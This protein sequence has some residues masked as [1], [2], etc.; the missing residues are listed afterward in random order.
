[1]R[2]VFH[3]GGYP[4]TDEGIGGIGLRILEFATTLAPDHQVLVITRWPTDLFPDSVDVHVT[5]GGNG[6]FSPDDVVFFFDLPDLAALQAAAKAGAVVV[7]ENAAPIEHLEYP[8]YAARPDGDD[9]L[10]TV[11]ATYRYQLRWSDH[12]VCRSDVERLTLV[13]NLAAVGRLRP[14]DIAA[15][16]TLDHLISLVPI[17]YTGR[18]QPAA[19]PPPGTEPRFAWSGGLWEFY[20]LELVADAVAVCCARGTPVTV[21]FLHGAPHPDN[22][23]VVNR[24]AARAT[25]LGLSDRVRVWSDPLPHT[26]RG[27]VLAAYHGLICLGRRGV[28][29][30]TCVRLRLRDSL[31]HRLPLIV[32]GHGAT[33]ALVGEHGLGMVTASDADAVADALLA[34]ATQPRLRDK[35]A[36]NLARYAEAVH[37]EI[38]LP[39]ALA[40]ARRH[41]RG[42]P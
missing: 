32:D 15:S 17:G 40:A 16:R 6:Q 11:T 28:E 20:D 41:A 33:G 30:Q 14:A 1:M 7:T 10:S 29:N 26:A 23:Q 36:D 35:I 5:A 37:Y 22:Q 3:A 2:V 27:A 19:G 31:L 8:T 18:D 38:T 4:L 34:I 39:R 9:H 24:L 13:A 42:T 25:V 21:D 12:F